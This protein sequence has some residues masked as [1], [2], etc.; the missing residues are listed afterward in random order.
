[1]SVAPPP[2]SPSAE[3]SRVAELLLKYW[4]LAIPSA[5]ASLVVVVVMIAAVLSVVATVLAGHAA[6]GHAGAA[7]G[8]GTGLLIGA[9]LFFAAM[10]GLYIAQGITMAGS[11][12]VLEDR[13]PD[14]GTAFAVTLTRLPELG[15]AGI[16]TLALAIVPLAL[17]IVLI[18]FP[19]LLLLGYFLMYV[20]AAVVV[21]NEGGIAA[22][23]TSFRITTQRAND[24][25]I[26]WLGILLAFV[27]GSI[28]N[29]VAI[30]IPLVNLIAGFA[31]GGFTSAYS[32]LLSVRFYLVLRNA[33][34]PS[35]VPSTAQAS[36]GG[37]PS[38]I[39]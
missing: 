6:A 12:A 5:V 17:C 18:G 22:I 29:S 28:V 15:V 10:I 37:P 27:A 19:L 39:R 35:P 9:A 3:L 31:V 16:A 1:L 11:P 7:M 36:Y 23:K 2:F 33:P 38:I 21:G 26:G 13:P 30:H 8:L 20:P 25:I 4:I 32:A 14:L 24:S 34:P